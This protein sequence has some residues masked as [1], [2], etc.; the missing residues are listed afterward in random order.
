[1]HRYQRFSYPCTARP[2]HSVHL[3]LTCIR[4]VEPAYSRVNGNGNGNGNG[5][6]APKATDPVGYSL[7]CRYIVRFGGVIATRG[8]GIKES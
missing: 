1:N 5:S 3:G 6:L 4:A 8:T 7:M 2:L